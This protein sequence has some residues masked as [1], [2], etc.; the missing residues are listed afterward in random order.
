MYISVNWLK[1]YVDLEGVNIE[2]LIDKFTLSCAK[3]E[4]IEYKEK[5]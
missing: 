2:N 3:V 4:G 1:D 5:K